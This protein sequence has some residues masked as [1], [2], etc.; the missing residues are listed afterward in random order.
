[1]VVIAYSNKKFTTI[2]A[3]IKG[4]VIICTMISIKARTLIA[5]FITERKIYKEMWNYYDHQ[6]I[7]SEGALCLEQKLCYSMVNQMNLIPETFVHATQAVKR[8]DRIYRS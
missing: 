5:F 7:S 6:R 4:L 3:I 1:M 8:V 2:E